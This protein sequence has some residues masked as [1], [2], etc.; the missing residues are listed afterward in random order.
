MVELILHRWVGAYTQKQRI[1]LIN[2][3]H[4]LEFADALDYSA[5]FEQ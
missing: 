2:S 3:E 1:K 5:A 4:T